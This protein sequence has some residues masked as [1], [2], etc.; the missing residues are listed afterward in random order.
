MKTKTKRSGQQTTQTRRKTRSPRHSGSY[1]SIPLA[2]VA[3]VALPKLGGQRS[4]ALAVSLCLGLMLIGMVALPAYAIGQVDIRGNLGTPTEDLYEAVGFAHGANA[5]LLRSQDVAAAVMAVT[6]IEAVHVQIALPGR[7]VITVKDAQPEVFWQTS[8]QTLW[9]DSK[10]VIYEQP[11]MTPERK[12][13]IKDVSGK[14]YKKGDRVDAS[15]LSGAREL[16]VLLAR[17][18]QEFEFQRDGELMV[19]STQAWK[20]LFNTRSDLEPQLAALRKTISSV[21][22]VTY[23]DVRVPSLVSYKLADTR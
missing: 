4:L 9:V 7:L 22:K 14:V 19:V 15:A 16:N 10:G 17:D 20:A 23:I 13:T 18:I 3:R 8:S 21:P 2:A 12:L 6:G 11:A 1:A 5:F